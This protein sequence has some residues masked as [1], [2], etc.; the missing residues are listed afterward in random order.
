MN[1]VSPDSPDDQVVN[2][3]DSLPSD[4]DNLS[5]ETSPGE[6]N[7][8]KRILARSSYR[9]PLPPPEVLNNYSPDVREVV[10]SMAMAQSRHRQDL[11]RQSLQADIN[12]RQDYHSEERKTEKR[13]QWMGVSISIGCVLSAFISM[14]LNKSP[15]VIAAFLS[16]PVAGIIQALRSST[17]KKD[18]P[19]ESSDSETVSKN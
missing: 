16:T 13:G 10:I 12:F 6:K 14:L 19:S 17:S 5:S 7:H 15:W 1:T 3:E 18:Q 2:S 8:I 9:G 4:L 11:E